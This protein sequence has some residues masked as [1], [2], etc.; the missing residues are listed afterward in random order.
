MKNKL[1]AIAIASALASVWSGSLLADG[2]SISVTQ[3]DSAGHVTGT[4]AA[5]D[6]TQTSGSSITI[7]QDDA[8]D[9]SNVAVTQS[10]A[11]AAKAEVQQYNATALDETGSSV[12]INQSGGTADAG[13][14]AKVIQGTQGGTDSNKG[15]T[16]T[17][18]TQ[19]GSGNSIVGF[20]EKDTTADSVVSGTNGT[21]AVQSGSANEATLNQD[22]TGNTM[23]FDQ[24]GSSNS[25]TLT[26]DTA[27]SNS[28]MNVK[29]SGAANSVTAGQSGAVG[30]DM[31]IEITSTDNAASSS[32]TVTATQSS[33]DSTMMATVTGIGNKAELE[34]GAN[35]DDS[36]M[37]LTQNGK[38]NDALMKQIGV[39]NNMSLSQ[40]N[41]DN[42]AIMTQ[43]GSSDIMTVSQAGGST[44]TLTQ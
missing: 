13:N 36:H 17:I 28:K 29:Q 3:T 24:Q 43:N 18:N 9:K 12:T 5:E 7:T 42:K 37:L 25:A 39:S 26:Q 4:Q 31:N 14:S 21:H 35:A 27:S 15:N 20:A 33:N 40:L 32:N 22:G 2:N 11:T 38:N 1:L 6:T 16:L 23:G 8:D 44:V 41:D 10:G 30:S 19:S 34:Q